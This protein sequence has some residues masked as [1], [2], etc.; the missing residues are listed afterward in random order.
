MAGSNDLMERGRRNSASFWL[1]LDLDDTLIDTSH[2]YWNARQVFADA[3]ATGLGIEISKVVDKF[4]SIDADNIRQYGLAPDRYLRSMLDTYQ[5]LAG[6]TA[7]GDLLSA[8]RKAGES[9][10][11]S[12]PQPIPGADKLLRWANYRGR[13]SLLTRGDHELQISK[14]E[15]LDWLQYF[16]RIRV[17]PTKGKEEL[18]SFLRELDYP[19]SATWVVGDSPTHDIYP[20]LEVGAKPILFNYRHHSYEWMF[21]RPESSHPAVPIADTLD[22]VIQIISNAEGE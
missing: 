10:F 8:C 18:E 6:S 9:I 19:I 20:A 7:T 2:V 16:E 3:I 17:V 15:R 4:E 14:V 13:C 1:V 5:I 12:L 21:D 22:E 11:T